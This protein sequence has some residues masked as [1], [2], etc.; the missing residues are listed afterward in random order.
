M[1]V[2]LWGTCDK[3]KPRTRILLEGLRAAG[4]EITEVHRDVWSGVEDK[5][6]LGALARAGRYLAW[7]AAYPG[8][9]ARF[10]AA[11]RPDVVFLAYPAQ[12]DALVLWAAA[13]LRRIPVAMDL[14]ISLYDTAVI[15]RGLTGRGSPKAR[16]IR[17]LEWLACRAADRVLIDTG[18]HARYIEELFALP[19][20]SV[21]SVPVGAE[22]GDFPRQPPVQPGER[23]RI[24]FY[25]QLIPLHGI[26][27]VLDAALSERGRN[28]DWV[29]IGSGQET[30]VV[31]ARLGSASPAHVTWKRWVPYEELAGEI[32]N[33]DLCLGV[34]GTS[35]KAAS[36]VPNKVYQCLASGRHVVTRA[37]PAM[38]ELAPD[39]D[40]GLTLVE[41]GSA[42]ALLDGIEASMAR[43]FLPASADLAASF[44][45][46]TIGQRL[47]G[48]LHL[49]RG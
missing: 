4:A 13:R 19:A 32:R 25:G 14:F 39:G 22:T 44:S 16:L 9:L 10:A 40:S 8:L 12:I 3:G 49:A 27:T 21:G 35:R 11:P 5:S 26:R 30:P 46:E 1:K 34:F 29:I 37:S 47:L 31:E 23:P 6:Q 24:L 33:S 18:P 48:E 20:D 15:D 38:D 41:A 42:D 36:V 28:F 17:G 43:G 45:I 7:I 2:L